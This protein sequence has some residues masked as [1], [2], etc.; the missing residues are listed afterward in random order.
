M[1]KRSRRIVA[2]A[3]LSGL[4][5]QMAWAT[6]HYPMLLQNLGT[7]ENGIPVNFLVRCIHHAKQQGIFA[8]I[9]LAPA[10]SSHAEHQSLMHHADAVGGDP[11]TS[12]SD[13]NVP[14]DELCTFSIAIVGQAMALNADPVN[15]DAPL[16][17]AGEYF[18]LIADQK[19]ASISYLAS[20]GRA[21]PA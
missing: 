3:A 4:L 5:L 18:S 2:L 15:L 19:A 11:Q 9:H 14:S 6:A 16:L 12:D 20:R 10:T 8:K 17:H 1:R 13:Q 7:T 21:P